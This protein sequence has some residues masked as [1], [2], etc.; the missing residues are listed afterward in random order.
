[1]LCDRL[2]CYLYAF[3]HFSAVTGSRLLPVDRTKH[4]LSTKKQGRDWGLGRQAHTHGLAACLL[5]HV[6]RLTL[7]V[8]ISAWRGV[9]GCALNVQRSSVEQHSMAGHRTL[10]L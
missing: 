8:S 3:V 1:M 6:G 9:S 5:L 4:T 7:H 10:L 2:H